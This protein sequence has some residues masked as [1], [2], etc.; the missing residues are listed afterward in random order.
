V[1]GCPDAATGTQLLTNEEHGY[2]LLYPTGY[3]VQHPKENETV[4]LLARC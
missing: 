3:E 4:I 1:E 2:C